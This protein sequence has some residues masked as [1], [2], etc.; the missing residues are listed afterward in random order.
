MTRAQPA[1]PTV[2]AAPPVFTR[3]TMRVLVVTSMYPT[4]RHPAYG[5][6]VAEQVRS[7]WAAG[8]HADV[9]FIDPRR[10]RLNY[11]L[12][13]RS[14]LARLRSARYDL[15]HTHH[16]YTV[17][18]THLAR[19]LAGR[20]VPLVLTNHEGE[21]LDPRP[22]RCPWHLTGRLRRSIA[23]KRYAARQADFVVFVSEAL[24]RVI[25]TG[26]RHTVIPCG[27][28]LDRFGPLDRD[29]CRARLGLPPRELVLFFPAGPRA[30]GKRFDLIAAAYDLVRAARPGAVLVTG[31][32]I[33]YE[34]MPLYYNAADVVLQ[35]SFYEASPTIVKE[36]LAC[37]VPLVSTDSGDTREIVG[38]VPACAICPDDPGA[39]AASAL[40]CAGRRAVG[41]RAQLRARGLALDQVAQRL[42]RVYRDLVA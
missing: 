21:A 34:M 28:D 15:V 40:A 11:A 3:D 12:C 27:I 17:P 31:G 39:L 8:V 1:L 24:S 16:T 35:S 41:G 38:D 9:L 18:V 14:V 25:A 22:D 13:L 37:E 4:P 2:A 7:L 10:T 23:L 29:R 32:A 33:P 26:R 19:V 20:R 6:F 42:L 5:A 30:R 36:A